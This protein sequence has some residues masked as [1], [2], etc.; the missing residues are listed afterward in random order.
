LSL[1]DED[2]KQQMLRT[3]DEYERLAQRAGNAPI[4][5]ARAPDLAGLKLS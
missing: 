1:K 2:A 3:A 4:Y 5:Q